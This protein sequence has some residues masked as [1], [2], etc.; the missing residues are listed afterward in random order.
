MDER[1]KGRVTNLA[2]YHDSVL[3]QYNQSE[4][5]HNEKNNQ[6]QAHYNDINHSYVVLSRN[7]NR[8]TNKLYEPDERS[9]R[10]IF[11]FKGNKI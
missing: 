8:N 5:T 4:E 1:N 2:S 9:G 11:Q 10:S 7:F 6:K 3:V